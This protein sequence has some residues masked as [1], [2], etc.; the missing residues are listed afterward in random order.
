MVTKATV[1][2]AASADAQFALQQASA[3]KSLRAILPTSR[4]DRFGADL[5]AIEAR[6]SEQEARR[7][8][9]LH[10]Q[11]NSPLSHRQQLGLLLYQADD[12]RSPLASLH[13]EV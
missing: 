9:Q 4:N 8:W 7:R 5:W 13:I 3:A 1:A 12:Q 2:P 11:Q 10:Q 6:G